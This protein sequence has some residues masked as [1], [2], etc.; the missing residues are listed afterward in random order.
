[1]IETP[2]EIIIVTDYAGQDLSG[3]IAQVRRFSLDKVRDYS[4]QILN[5]M[6]YLN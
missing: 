2:K 3:V 4:T 5:A 6:L 1:M